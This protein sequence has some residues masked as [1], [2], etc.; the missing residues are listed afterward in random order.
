MLNHYLLIA[1]RILKKNPTYSF[2][3]IFGLAIG[4]ASALVI[5]LWVNQETS[6]DKHFKNSEYIYRTGI[7]FF[8]LGDMAVGPEILSEKLLEYPNIKQTTYVQ[9]AG[10]L[11]L[12]VDDQVFKQ[13]N[14]FNSEKHFFE[15]FQYEFLDGENDPFSQPRSAVISDQVALKLYGTINAAGKTFTVKD[16]ETFMVT[17]VV[18]TPPK[19]HLTTEVWLSIDEKPKANWYSAS[20]FSYA[21]T[22]ESTDEAG[23]YE[24]LDR[25]LQND[26][27]ATVAPDQDFQ[28]WKESGI[29]Q[30]LPYPLHDIYLQSDLKYEPTPGG[31][32]AAVKIFSVV[33]ILILVLAAVNYINISTARSLVRAKEVGIRK[34]I[35][36]SRAELSIQFFMESVLVCFIALILAIVMGELF[37]MGFQS[38]T[39]LQ[40]LESIFDQSGA[41]II[42][43]MIA[44]LFGVLAG[45]YPTFY[46]TRFKPGQV[47]KGLPDNKTKNSF[48]SVLVVIQFTISISLIVVCFFMYQQIRFMENK[49]L[50]FQSE[51]ILMINELNQIEEHKDY[52][53]EQLSN[54]PAVTSISLSQRIPTTT[55]TWVQSLKADDTQEEQW[56]QRFAGDADMVETMGYKILEGRGF[57]RNLKSDT[58]SIILN[59]RAVQQFALEDP[60]GAT[61]GGG[62]TKVIGIVQDFNFQSLKNGVEPVMLMMLPEREKGDFLV[63][64]YNNKNSEEIIA[65]AEEVW[66]ELGVERPMTYQYLD[67]NIAKLTAEERILS[68]ALTLF[69]ALAIAISC[70]GLYGL[71][72]FISQQ[73]TKE[74]GI[75][76]VLGASITN[77][78]RLL[79]WSFLKPVLIA[80]LI[81][82]P[83]SYFAVDAWLQDFHYRIEISMLYFV[84]SCLL[85]VLIGLIT[86]SGHSVIT[87]LRN[88]V[89]SLRN[90]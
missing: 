87:A 69:T 59:Q 4:F 85:A 3:N 66:N 2:I 32:A 49:D 44:L 15:V 33:A 74:I 67:E 83:L 24:I 18:K 5:G 54:L 77:L 70:L 64:R 29:Y 52:F 16:R 23:F 12:T 34:A 1:I 14:V 76:K 90:E 71:S 36:T 41:L 13:E 81:A 62:T 6:Y 78:V 53:K 61:F 84:I 75:R 47:L 56:I 8:N 11:E 21:L 57:D 72:A 22:D 88:P 38:Y 37:L 9:S 46:I 42:M 63:I 55:S 39:G 26:V 31:N 40:L 58:A 51:Q 50:G 35:G 28:E 68:K 19:T 89:D 79:N 10:T 7:N 27:H 48:R 65:A 17:G 82:I 25:I 20:V 43:S 60:I 86:V 30:L 73:R 80:S 45:L